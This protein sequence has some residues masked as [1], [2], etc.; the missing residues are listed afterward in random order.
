MA[1]RSKDAQNDFFPGLA[2]VV[3]IGMGSLATV[4]RAREIGTN[5]M[6][7]LKLLNVRDASPRAL[8]SF[9]R[10]SVALGAVSSHPNIVTL[11]RSFRAADGR[12]VLVLELCRGTVADQL[13]IGRG[14]PVRDVVAL[15]IKIAAALESAHRADILHRDV[16]P[17]NMLITEYGEPALADFGVAMLQASTQT[18]AGLFDFTTLHAA[19]ELLEGGATSAATDVYELASSLYQLITGKSAFRAYEGE[20]PASV[21]LRI[22]RDPVQ[23]LISAQVPSQLSELL[24]A[25]MSKDKASRPP[26]AAQFAS[27]LMAVESAQ[28]WRPTPFLIREP[29]GVLVAPTASEVPAAGPLVGDPARGAADDGWSAPSIVELHT[30]PPQPAPR[31]DADWSSASLVRQPD[32]GTVAPQAPSSEVEPPADVTR[33]RPLTSMLPPAPPA[34]IQ[35]PGQVPPTA[36]GLDEEPP[37]DVTRRRPVPPPPPPPP[38]R[39]PMETLPAPLEPAPLDRSLALER[40]ADRPARHAFLAAPAPEPPPPAP[41]P[42]PVPAPALPPSNAEQRREPSFEIL[43]ESEW[44]AANWAPQPGESSSLYP[45][46]PAAGAESEVPT[47]TGPVP[48]WAFRPAPQSES[49]PASVPVG[50]LT[51]D[52][53]SLRRRMTIRSG[54]AALT[55]DETKLVLRHWL[56]KTE[57][58]WPAIHGFEPR[59]DGVSASGSGG[60]LVALT[61]DGPVELPATKRSM[62]DLRYLHALLDAYR[63]RALSER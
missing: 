57:I 50:D 61:N 4:Y 20:S 58:Q 16:K 52:P 30:P 1:R 5:R 8:E 9:E 17:Q 40:D 14:L 55:V 6:V 23:P 22:L 39:E 21:I 13:Q 24:V 63:Q 47:A 11:F 56:R 51:L 45:V 60:R 28:Q 33:H 19:P 12:P 31:G 37:A 25:A 18:T 3:Q 34:E 27:Q 62:A 44:L 32:P 15:G 49:P 26:T 46:T 35:T 38:P 54:G 59:F 48:T 29:G 53:E 7:A 36:E 2:D 41:E 10:E 43:P 42:L